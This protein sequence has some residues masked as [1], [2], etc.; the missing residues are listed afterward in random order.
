[1]KP[2]FVKEADIIKF[3]EPEK[4]VVE[5]PNVQMYP[6]FIT[7]VKDLHN[8]KDRGEISQASHDKLYADLINRF[9]KKESFETPWF[10]RESQKIL[11]A[12]E[13]FKRP[14]R[15]PQFISDIKNGVEFA[16][17]K[18]GD[19]N[20][21]P[22]TINPNEIPTIQQWIDNNDSSQPLKLKT[23]A[24]DLTIGKTT[25]NPF[26]LMKTSAYGGQQPGLGGSTTGGK[27]S[28]KVK[29][30]D[31]GLHD[32]DIPA[33][34]LGQAI[35]GNKVL[36]SSQTGKL[37]IAMANAI[38]KGTPSIQDVDLKGSQISSIRD[39]A[40]EYLG[41]LMIVKGLADFPNQ[42]PFYK[43]LKINNL[44]EL[45][46]NF[47]SKSN[48]PLADSFGKFAG[49]KNIK[50]GFTINI[51]VKGGTSGK[52]AAP[53]L[54][55]FKVP[56]EFRKRK[57][58]AEE[59]EFIDANRNNNQYVFP[60]V[61]LNIIHKYHPDTVPAYIKKFLPFTVIPQIGKN[62]IEKI[63]KDK[64]MIR[65]YK[66][67]KSTFLDEKGLTSKKT[68]PSSIFNVVHYATEMAVEKSL[69]EGA[70]P[71][72]SPLFREM[73]QQNFV[74]VSNTFN[75]GV[76]KTAVLW[77]N[78]DLASGNVVYDSKNSMSGKGIQSKACIRI[79]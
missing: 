5:L 36:Q 76:F 37:V 57:E 77:P 53:A 65:I 15:L 40:G 31:I 51:S 54:S 49:V 3:P 20:P 18:T 67:V 69:Q 58:F 75:S 60:F 13:L 59:I 1:M 55:N 72:L 42:Q 32:K 70:L 64:T 10:L 50:E 78:T 24:G 56:D 73:L 7:G 2:W 79:Q 26:Q 45:V 41:L 74:Q 16:A 19:T 17:L 9:M 8:R 14:K 39:Y 47:P 23:S 52:G 62:D 38:L 71:D 11:S 66:A 48:E 29:A 33:K 30:T 6:D 44:D 61:L 46:V 25:N 63:S 35:I 43:H 4:K 34:S 28:K 12:D 27:E 68:K 21:F 22:V